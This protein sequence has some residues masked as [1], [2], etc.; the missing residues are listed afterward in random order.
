MNKNRFV[1]RA[2]ILDMDG[3]ITR[4]AV[5]H[6]KAWKQMF[7]DLLRKTSGDNFRPLDIRE[8]YYRYIDGIPRHDGIRNFLKSRNLVIPDGEPDDGAEVDTIYGIGARKNELFLSILEKEGVQVYEDTVDAIHKWKD[9]GIK[10]GIISSSRNCKRIIEATG[11]SDL[12]DTRV[13]GTTLASE[14]LNG[15]PEPDMFL[16]ACELMD[17]RPSQ[18]IVIEDAIAGI[19]AGR[20]GNFGLVI[21]IARDKDEKQLIEAGA[22][23]VAKDL[24]DIITNSGQLKIID[25]IN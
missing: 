23:L 10:L 15:K 2:A 24:T 22:D 12:F 11:L 3:V 5:I 14:N 21:G 7:D 6:A 17:V 13:D 1:F 20:R 25:T 19:E 9:A 8:D 4:T 16:R 18:T